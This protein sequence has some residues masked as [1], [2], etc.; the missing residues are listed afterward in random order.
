MNLAYLE[1]P[2]PQDYYLFSVSA[3][4]YY[5]RA[6]KNFEDSSV[7]RHRLFYAALEC[8]FTIEMLLKEYMAAL[9]GID[10]TR[11]IKRNYKPTSLKKQINRL[12]PYLTY[13][14]RFANAILKSNN[15]DFSFPILDL[16]KLERH[17]NILNKY[18]HTDYLPKYLIEAEWWKVFQIEIHDILDDIWPCVAMPKASLTCNDSGMALF[19]RYR[20]N[21][22]DDEAIAKII[23]TKAC[24]TVEITINFKCFPQE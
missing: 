22:L 24:G 15:T 20:R 8:R 14:I 16:D 6:F 10:A 3:R 23:Q 13:K 2:D 9:G 5:S 21:E 18:L 11:T 19:H 12:E 7:E 17:Y 4:E 1:T